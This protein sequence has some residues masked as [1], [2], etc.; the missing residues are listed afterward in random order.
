M[1]VEEADR[2]D[3]P[4]P[5]SA[6]VKSELAPIS[7]AP[8]P[9]VV[10]DEWK[11]ELSPPAT[12]VPAQDEHVGARAPTRLNHT[13]EQMLNWLVM[14]PDKSLRELAD[15]MGYTQSWVSTILHSDI[16]QLA[17]KDRQM[18]VA[19][20]VTG[21]IPE[22]LRRA[23]D[24]ATDKLATMVEESEDPEFIL[25][26]TDKILHRMGYAPQSARNPAGSPGAIAAN[27]QQNNFFL[28]AKDLEVARELMQASAIRV[29][30]PVLAAEAGDEGA[31]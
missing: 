24:I 22:K 6:P 21:S 12:W 15:Q 13:H 14:N 10:L 4:Q 28:Q 19:A 20:R 8:G 29:G 16:F 31:Q 30:A 1:N 7:L 23:A 5:A 9:G 27:M 2:L 17:L 18:E 25:D 11:E 26:A 3:G